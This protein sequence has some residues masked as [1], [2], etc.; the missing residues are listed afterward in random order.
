MELA[1]VNQALTV[2]VRE[3]VPAQA[4]ERLAKMEKLMKQILT[5]TNYSVCIPCGELVTKRNRCGYCCNH[6]CGCGN[7]HTE[8][9]CPIH[10]C[11]SCDHMRCLGCQTQW[12][13][14]C[15]Q[16]RY[17]ECTNCEELD[18]RHC[19]HCGPLCSD[20]A[21]E[22]DFCAVCDKHFCNDDCSQCLECL[23]RVCT[24]CAVKRRC[25]Q[26][27]GVLCGAHGS[28]S[29]DQWRHCDDCGVFCQECAADDFCTR[30]HHHLCNSDRWTCIGCTAVLCPQC[31]VQRCTE[32]HVALCAGCDKSTQFIACLRCGTHICDKAQAVSCERCQ[33]YLH[34]TCYE[35]RSVATLCDQCLADCQIK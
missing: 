13:G 3:Q 25:G 17:R 14:P 22:N 29:L 15:A 21:D 7:N 20:C 2:V 32:C 1:R 19:D 9:Y 16:C 5:D 24:T 28:A 8:E 6:L 18:W 26:C 33:G 35:P 23:K 10:E 34:S 11:L 12:S 27:E 30:C 31:A 4:Q